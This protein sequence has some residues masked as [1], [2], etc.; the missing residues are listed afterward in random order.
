M[1]ISNSDEAT[2]KEPAAVFVKNKF[3]PDIASIN[4]LYLP[5]LY[6]EQIRGRYSIFKM[7]SPRSILLCGFTSIASVSAAVCTGNIGTIASLVSTNA[8][9]Q[10]YCTAK[11]L[12]APVTTTVTAATSTVATIG[13]TSTVVSVTGTSTLT[14]VVATSTQ[15]TT[16]TIVRSYDQIRR[17]SL[18]DNIRRIRRGNVPQLA[19]LPKQ[20][21]PQVPKPVCPLQSNSKERMIRLTK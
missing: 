3:I 19:L 4:N 17:K 11:Y 5:F 12:L 6:L 13:A 9:A 14:T 16:V 1:E 10:S 7:V 21:R 8:A 2:S 18:A 20:L 15:F